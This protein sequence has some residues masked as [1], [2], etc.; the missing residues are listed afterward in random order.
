MVKPRLLAALLLMSL[1]APVASAASMPW[2]KIADVNHFHKEYNTTAAFRARWWDRSV[3]IDIDLPPTNAIYVELTA[4]L[5]CQNGIPPKYNV[6]FYVSFAGHNMTKKVLG[7]DT[8]GA[9]YEAWLKLNETVHSK[10]H[11]DLATDA[12]G[13]TPYLHFAMVVYSASLRETLDWI[14]PGNATIT[15]EYQPP[16]PKPEALD[17]AIV[18]KL[19][20]GSTKTTITY[21]PIQVPVFPV[22][23]ELISKLNETLHSLEADMAS[24]IIN[25]TAKLT[26][27]ETVAEKARRI[28]PGLLVATSLAPKQNEQKDRNTVTLYEPRGGNYTYLPIIPVEELVYIKGA[29]YKLL[30]N[31]YLLL[32]NLQAT[33]EIALVG[34]EPAG[35]NIWWPQRVEIP[36]GFI[37]LPC[38]TRINVYSVDPVIESELPNATTV[39]WKDK[40]YT[41]RFN[42]SWPYAVIKVNNDTVKGKLVTVVEEVTICYYMDHETCAKQPLVMAYAPWGFIDIRG[43]NETTMT[44][45]YGVP[46]LFNITLDNRTITGVLSNDRLLVLVYGDMDPDTS[47]TNLTVNGTVSG[48]VVALTE[49]PRIAITVGRR[50]KPIEPIMPGPYPAPPTPNQVAEPYRIHEGYLLAFNVEHMA[51]EFSAAVDVHVRDAETGGPVE[52]EVL[53]LQNGTIVDRARGS[54]VTLKLFPGNYTLEARIGSLAFYKNVA[55]EDDMEVTIKVTLPKVTNV[56]VKAPRYSLGATKL[57]ITVKLDKPAPADYNITGRIIVDSSWERNFTIPVKANETKAST[58]VK[59]KLSEG[60]HHIKIIVGDVV[61][62]TEVTVAGGSLGFA[63]AAV[64]GVTAIGVVL[65]VLRRPREIAF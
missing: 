2:I 54:D 63:V 7:H 15:Y 21:H 22:P 32:N 65:F 5:Q 53:A 38:Y 31:T 4:K 6:T 17:I 13:C 34:K 50:G 59:L 10:L 45:Q 12:A 16:K 55:V 36:A 49:K 28:P 24:A 35:Y 52:A 44:I 11:I 57:R 60:K 23:D 27:N 25:E 42:V 51:V 43:Y 40:N 37:Y 64:V 47:L 14:P 39:A 29:K 58:A 33:V 41:V 9:E 62:E 19:D 8:L 18:F 30:N 1:L 20:P 46:P 3:P 56:T 61:A 48:V 26:H